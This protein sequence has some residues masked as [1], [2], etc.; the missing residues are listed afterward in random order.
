MKCTALPLLQVS[1]TFDPMCYLSLPLPVKKE[2]QIEVFLVYLDPSRP[3]TQFK[4]NQA[5]CYVLYS[6]S[7]LWAMRPGPC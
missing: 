5:P 1:V 6:C 7:L 2:R 3:P 4:V